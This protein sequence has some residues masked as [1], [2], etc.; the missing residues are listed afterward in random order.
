MLS[1]LVGRTIFGFCQASP[2]GDFERLSANIRQHVR[3]QPDTGYRKS[4][5]SYF[6]TAPD[7]VVDGFWI[8]NFV[9]G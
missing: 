1:A 3:E 7:P 6:V 5:L 2:V 8:C 4:L 9:M